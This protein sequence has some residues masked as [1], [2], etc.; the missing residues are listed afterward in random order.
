MFVSKIIYYVY[1]YSPI[2]TVGWAINEY[3]LG[4]F[5]WRSYYFFKKADEFVDKVY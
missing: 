3:L 5:D 1:P 4:F 2:G